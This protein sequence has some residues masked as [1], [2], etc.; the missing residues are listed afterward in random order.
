MAIGFI[1]LGVWAHH[2]FV[3]GMGSDARTA[4][5]AA[6]TMLVAIP[7]GIKIFNWLAHDVRRPH[8]L[9]HADAVLPAPSCSSSC[10][11]A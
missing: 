7:T 2:M 10:A 8:P 9:R 11:A 6:A 3:V 1:S 5:F 4:F